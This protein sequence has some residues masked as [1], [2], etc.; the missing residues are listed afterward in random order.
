M[1][2][3]WAGRTRTR[4]RRPRSRWRKL[5]DYGLTFTFFLLL[6]LVASRLDRLSTRE[7]TGAATVNDGDTLTLGTTRVRL[8]GI[9]APEYAQTCTRAGA[10]YPCG[11]MARQALVEL[12]RGRSVTCEGWRTDRYGRLLGD[13]RAGDVEV[14]RALVEAGWA[15]AHGDFEG[16]E[17]KARAAGRGIWAGT[18]QRPQDW[19]REH[20]RPTED[21]HDRLGSM[22]AAVAELFRFR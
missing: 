10:D 7:E 8:R 19:R 6:S 18:F 14:N 11:K 13:C 4:G 5:L 20:Q 1:S 9:D 2:R 17:A 22:A 15:V 12:T 16:E 3:A 21:R